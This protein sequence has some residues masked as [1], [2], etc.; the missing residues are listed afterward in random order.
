ML[1]GTSGKFRCADGKFH[2]KRVTQY[3]GKTEPTLWDVLN[4]EGAV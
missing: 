3:R 1:L 4:L 2:D